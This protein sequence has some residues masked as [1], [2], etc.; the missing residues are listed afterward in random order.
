MTTPDPVDL[1]FGDLRVLALNCTLKRSPAPSNT[2][3]LME[4]ALAIMAAHGV[5]VDRVRAVDHV[6]APGVQ[7]DMTEH[8]AERDDW[9]ALQERVLAADILLLGTP[10]WLGAKSSVCT[11]VVERLYGFSG[12]L[13]ATG[14]RRTTGA[15]A[16][17]W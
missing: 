12:E 13:N 2:A 8:G 7:G 10:I 4:N 11:S 15:S 9:P 3:A 6:I 16:A 17:S 5:A 14:S 1:D